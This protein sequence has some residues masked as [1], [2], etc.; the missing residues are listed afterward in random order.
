[1]NPWLARV[2]I[3]ELFWGKKSLKGDAKP[4]QTIL[5]YESELR[6]ALNALEPIMTNL[7][8]PKKGN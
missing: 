3:T 1:M 4:I 5:S 2:L 7:N 8:A 6:E